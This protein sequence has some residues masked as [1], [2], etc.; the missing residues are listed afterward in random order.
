MALR[1]SGPLDLRNIG[2]SLPAVTLPACTTSPLRSNCLYVSLHEF[3]NYILPN[4]LNIENITK[5]TKKKKKKNEKLKCCNSFNNVV[6]EPASIP[7]DELMRTFGGDFLLL[8][9]PIFNK[10]EKRQTP[11]F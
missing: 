9:C 6:R 5:L 2:T 10:H 7:G 8:Y 11:K 3:Y 4:M 1:T